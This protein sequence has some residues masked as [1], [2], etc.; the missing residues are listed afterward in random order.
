MA[1]KIVSFPS[2]PKDHY[3]EHYVSALIALSGRFVERSIVKRGSEEILELDIVTSKFSNESIDKSIVEIKGGK[4]WGFP[5]IFKVRGWMDYLGL[6]K[7]FFIVQDTTEKNIEFKKK[8][9]ADL[10]IELLANTPNEK[11]KLD[12]KEIEEA[13]GKIE[14]DV[15]E[16]ALSNLRY[17]FCMEDMMLGN[18]LRD[19]RDENNRNGYVG[20]QR[21][22]QYVHVIHN[23]SFF[24][25]DPIDRIDRI[26]RIF[27]ENRN[28]TAGILNEDD[29]FGYPDNT[30]GLTIP[31]SVFNSIFYEI[32]DFSPVYI[33]LHAELLNRI[34]VLK[35]CIE[36]IILKKNKPIEEGI[37]HMLERLKVYKIP[38]NLRD[39]VSELEKR[40]HFYLYPFFWQIYVYLF[41]GFI[42]LSKKEEE[43]ALLSQ[44]TGVPA[45]EIDFALS[46]FD[47]LF[48]IED[49]WHQE[50]RNHK[51]RL[52]KLFPMPLRGVGANF[53]RQV[54][55]KDEERTFEGLNASLGLPSGDYTFNEIVK[56]NNLAYNTLLRDK[57]L[58]KVKDE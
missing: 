34:L 43:Y 55:S 29:V 44:I 37:A 45:D 31:R 28:I 32:T 57:T 24:E 20:Y 1:E 27:T 15:R 58:V 33:A 53:R 36:Y 5:D 56:W 23:V 49:S 51:V 25:S 54:Y 4:H 10:E 6:N 48:P 16:A 9:A 30:D 13:F 50:P 46:I 8:I 12:D 18:L 3:Y 47:L 21:L 39:G 26:F 2:I 35:S 38:E 7:A 11:K 41:G 40:D 19:A 42:I 22:M 52:L 14:F 17:A